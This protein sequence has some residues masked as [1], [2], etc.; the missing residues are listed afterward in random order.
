MRFLHE[1]RFYAGIAISLSANF[2]PAF[3]QSLHPMHM[4]DSTMAIRPCAK[5]Q[6]VFGDIIS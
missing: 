1:K 4:P 3:K 5:H 6:M 2:I